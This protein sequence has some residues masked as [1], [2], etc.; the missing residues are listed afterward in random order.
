MAAGDIAFF[1]RN[2]GTVPTQEV[3]GG[4]VRLEEYLRFHRNGISNTDWQLAPKSL[5]Q[6]KSL[7]VLKVLEESS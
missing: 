5:S 1:P 3:P 7:A 4:R 2:A 6:Q